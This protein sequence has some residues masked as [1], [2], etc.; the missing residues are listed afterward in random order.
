MSN[1]KTF[2]IVALLS[3]SLTIA[4]MCN[5]TAKADSIAIQSTPVLVSGTVEQYYV[6]RAGYVSALNLETASGTQMVHFSPSWAKRLLTDS[7]VGKTMD[8]WVIAHHEGLW[9]WSD[10]VS[11]GKAPATRILKENI[12]TGA[13]QLDDN[14]WIWKKGSN[15][16]VSG[17]LEKIVINRNGDVLALV[18][19]NGALVR[20]PRTVRNEELGAYGTDAIAPLFKDVEVTAWGTPEWQANGDVSIYN[21]HLSTTGLSINGKTVS[22]V[23]IPKLPVNQYFLSTGDI[24]LIDA[25][26]A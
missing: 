13:Q 21:Q 20:V 7:P 23:G 12:P 16:E 11:I 10:L 22:A 19:D 18:L 26:S 8:G 5:Q 9:A 24:N 4:P 3:M 25:G 17:K 6:N 15:V 2:G 14:S 1:W